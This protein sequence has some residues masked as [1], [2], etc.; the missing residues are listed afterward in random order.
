[1]EYRIGNPTRNVLETLTTLEKGKH[2]FFFWIRY[3]AIIGLLEVE[4]HLV[5][6]DDLY[7]GT[8]SYIQKCS[9]KQ[10]MKCIFIDMTDV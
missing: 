5:V 2:A 8:N 3:P 6:E 7:G 4:D 10:G 1:M 9:S